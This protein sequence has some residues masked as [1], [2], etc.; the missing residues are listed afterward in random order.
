M[1]LVGRRERGKER[2]RERE[3]EREGGEREREKRQINGYSIIVHAYPLL[4]WLL[5]SVG[6]IRLVVGKSLLVTLFVCVVCSSRQP[7]RNN[8]RYTW[9]NID[10]SSR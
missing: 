1:G 7:W 5:V 9:T 10:H 3:R 2:E 6:N 4:V 8:T